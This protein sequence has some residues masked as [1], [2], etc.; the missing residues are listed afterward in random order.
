MAFYNF[1]YAASAIQSAN[2][3]NA[4]RNISPPFPGGISTASQNMGDVAKSQYFQLSVM[5]TQID[6]LWGSHLWGNQKYKVT[7]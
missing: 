3:L 1:G 4:A 7:S 5:S 6:F 2:A